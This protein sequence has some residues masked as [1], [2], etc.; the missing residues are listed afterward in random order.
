MILKKV[1]ELTKTHHEILQALESPMLGMVCSRT[2]AF[3]TAQNYRKPESSAKGSLGLLDWQ[4][5][6]PEVSL[7][8]LTDF[9]SMPGEGWVV[10][11]RPNT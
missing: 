8:L 1:Q 2:E 11:L 3:K 4:C 6:C 10:L 5:L 9:S 7:K